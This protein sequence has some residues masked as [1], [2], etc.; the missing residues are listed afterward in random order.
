MHPGN[1]RCSLCTGT[2]MST[3]TAG[4]ARPFWSR[5]A[6]KFVGLAATAV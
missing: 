1:A 6:Q 3:V 2:T 4:Q 5:G